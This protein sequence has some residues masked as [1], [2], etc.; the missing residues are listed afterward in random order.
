MER[1]QLEEFVSKNREE[2]DN[3]EPSSKVWDAVEQSLDLP[4]EPKL[5]P[6]RK[7]LWYGAAAVLVVAL[8]TSLIISSNKSE[9]IAKVETK[10]VV[11]NLDGYSLSDVSPELAEVEGY[12]VTRV[13]QKMEKLGAMDVDPELLVEIDLLDQEFKE[14]KLA[15]GE[16]VNNEQLIQ[17]MIDNYRLKLE[18]LEAMIIEFETPEEDEEANPNL[19]G[20]DNSPIV[21][22]AF[23][24]T[25]VPTSDPTVDG[26]TPIVP[27]NEEDE[28]QPPRPPSPPQNSDQTIPLQ[29]D[30]ADINDDDANNQQTPDPPLA[31]EDDDAVEVVI[32]DDN[33]DDEVVQPPPPPPLP[34]IEDDTTNEDDKNSLQ[35]CGLLCLL[36][37]AVALRCNVTSVIICVQPPRLL[38]PHA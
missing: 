4:E 9:P 13:N 8:G 15:M 35:V 33:D 1:E 27:V 37:V 26:D 11:E 34:E 2:F 32:A 5:V 6:L 17:A 38:Q 24:A 14:L 18:I 31:S 22:K 7:A 20:D 21:Q 19:S 16:S 23:E 29:L 3:L 25:D 10:E 12:Y 28:Q 30:D 36:V